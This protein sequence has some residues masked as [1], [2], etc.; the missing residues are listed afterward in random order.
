M[1]AV[2]DNA[3]PL[4][5]VFEDDGLVPNNILPF[6]VYQG[7][8]KLDSRQ[9]EET[10]RKYVR[11]ERLGRDVAQWGLRLSALSRDGA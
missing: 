6:L 9:P 2:R 3:E 10:N 11:S 8:V 1:P 7:A 4:A 5:I